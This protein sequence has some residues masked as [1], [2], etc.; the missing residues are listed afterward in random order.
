MLSSG[1]ERGVNQSYA[2][3]DALLAREPNREGS[4]RVRSLREA[5][6]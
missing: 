4:V 6:R 5:L 2:A 1:M 3:L